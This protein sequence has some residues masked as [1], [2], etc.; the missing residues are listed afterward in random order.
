MGISPPDE[1]RIEQRRRWNGHSQYRS[2][3]KF[4]SIL[5]K[6]ALQAWSRRKSGHGLTAT[7]MAA[8]LIFSLL[9]RMSSGS[10]TT[11]RNGAGLL[12]RKL[13]HSVNESPM[14][15][16][17]VR[18]YELWKP[19][20][21]RETVYKWAEH[22]PKLITVTTAQEAYGLS[23]AG[24]S[25]D[26]PFETENRGCLNYIL[27]LQDLEAHPPGSDSA[28][29]LPEVLWSGELH[30]NERVGPTAVLEAVD[31]LLQATACEALPRVALKPATGDTEPNG[32][33]DDDV[34][35]KELERAYAC[36]QDLV[37]KGVDDAHRRWLARLLT[38]RRIVVVPTANA[39]GYYQNNR[40]ENGIDPNRDFPYDVTSPASCMQTIAGRT[41]NEVFRQHMFQLSLTF[42]GGMEVVGYEWGAPT[43]Q[44]PSRL[45][46]DNTAQSQI[47]KAYSQY[48]GGSARIDPYVYG[49]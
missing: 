14:E 48:A 11:S 39:L 30:G 19:E 27:T 1:P 25:E 15:Q 20:E 38:T 6:M 29:R 37:Q 28:K 32:T 49:P 18:A 16:T 46:P 12:L 47:A 35:Q 44:D 7:T 9:P 24:N 5:S 17:D 3:S 41:L 42:H 36:R 34:W 10:S 21:I 8:L 40:E 45:S 26:C 2:P 22:Y 33:D 23:T 31:L 4:E 43:W 13:H